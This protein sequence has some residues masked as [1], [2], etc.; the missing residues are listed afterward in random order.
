VIVS[1]YNGLYSPD[2][3]VNLAIYGSGVARS[4]AISSATNSYDPFAWVLLVDPARKEIYGLGGAD[5]YQYKTYS[6]SASGIT[7]K[8]STPSSLTY[9]ANDTDEA[10]IVAG[11]MYTDYGQVVDPESGA[12]LGTLYS[13]ATIWAQG[14]AT[15][16][17]TL[18]KIFVL[19]ASINS[20]QLVAF[21]LANLSRTA[22][23]AIPISL[24]DFQRAYAYGGPTGNRLTRWAA[25]GLALR[26]PGGFV[27][28]CTSL[29]RDLS[30]TDADLGVSITATGTL[31]TGSTN[32]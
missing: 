27:S 21:N 26:S 23:P 28:L 9:A 11:R 30:S 22:A 8:S 2:S 31:T 12:L 6:Y 13:S 1:T 16:D 15:V 5:N 29:V 14:S 10:Q 3:G 25:N 20:H 19:E 7:L 18:G 32:S 4:A 24:P 17:T